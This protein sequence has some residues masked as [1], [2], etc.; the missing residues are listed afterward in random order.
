MPT[1]ISIVADIISELKAIQN[2][3]NLPTDKDDPFQ[4][5][6]MIGTGDG[7]GIVVSRTV[8]QLIASASRELKSGDPTLAQRVKD[9]EWNTVV[10]GAFGAPL[11]KIDLDEDLRTNAKAVLDDVQASI[12]QSA[13]KYGTREYAFGCTLFSGNTSRS[14]PLGFYA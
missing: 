7:N 5:P 9:E 3:T 8:D 10:R 6:R 4:L 12:I 11:A 14:P 13:S 2:A 1:L